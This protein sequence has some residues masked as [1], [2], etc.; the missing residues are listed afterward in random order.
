[1]TFAPAV[2]IPEGSLGRKTSLAV[3][4]IPLDAI[5]LG[6]YGGQS[7][8]SCFL[9]ELG[10]GGRAM[11]SRAWRIGVIL[12]GLGS[13][14]VDGPST[15][16][17]L[18][19]TNPFAQSIKP[20]NS[21]ELPAESKDEAIRVVRVGAQVVTANKQLG[22]T[23]SFQ[24]IGSPALEIFH[25]GNQEV[26]I[27]LGLAQKCP[28]DGL[29]AAVLC[30]ELARMVAE[31]D[32]LERFSPRAASDPPP[33][34]EVRV[35]ND[36]HGTYGDFDRTHQMELARYEEEMRER[37]AQAVNPDTLARLYLQKAGYPPGL[38]TEAAPLLKAAEA[39]GTLEKQL[40]PKR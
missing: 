19:H 14:C 15:T 33:P 31:R 13:G 30:K 5:P 36:S 17:P 37:R 29:L 6:S 20:P 4:E 21:P 24:L 39:N 11:L 12:A 35:G 22:L 38:L 32:A 25:R 23:P 18:V 7:V 2:L 9:A 34:M 1:M 40:K 26:F 3:V 27:T 28:S 16:T 10:T 8:R